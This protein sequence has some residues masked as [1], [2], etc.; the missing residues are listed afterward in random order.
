[1]SEVSAPQNIPIDH[2]I[3]PSTLDIY[4][5]I[6]QYRITLRHRLLSELGKVS[7]FILESLATEG[8]SLE[9][10]KSIT[11]LSSEHL[12]PILE[13]LIGL[14]WFDRESNQLTS[15]GYD[16]AKAA[17]LSGQQFSIWIDVLNSS[18]K[19]LVTTSSDQFV[20]DRL[21]DDAFI[22]NEFERDWKIQG[23]IQQQRLTRQ[24]R[25]VNKNSEGNFLPLMYA[26]CA[27]EYH[28]ILQKQKQS[29][30]L[31]L[32]IER[33]QTNC[34]YAVVQLTD[35]SR[36]QQVDSV[37]SRKI[38]LYAP[39]LKYQ[40]SF[41]VP[42]LVKGSVEQPKIEEQF[43]CMLGGIQLPN[44]ELL[45]TRSSWPESVQTPLNHLLAQIDQQSRP[46]SALVSRQVEL[47]QG[48]RKLMLDRS[49]LTKYLA[50][51]FHSS[52]GEQL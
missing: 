17:Q 41:S 32:E 6:R 38:S 13:R 24:L 31:D 16:M 4:V 1:M 30:T 34:H 37:H 46:L 40:A 20:L 45:N 50:E 18:E 2:S 15:L 29:W 25:P 14:Q 19:P 52:L 10:I 3:I 12:A 26:L 9:D 51:Q 49:L 27:D 39:V 44:T 33:E 21:P 35:N 5:P 22:I 42:D 28:S 43:F 7:Q 47:I 23:V 36:M 8:C 11:S 48:C